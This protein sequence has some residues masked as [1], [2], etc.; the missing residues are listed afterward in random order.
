MTQQSER[1]ENVAFLPDES[2]LKSSLLLGTLVKI[3]ICECICGSNL[4]SLTMATTH[5]SRQNLSVLVTQRVH[6]TQLLQEFPLDP[7]GDQLRLLH[8]HAKSGAGGKFYSP[9]TNP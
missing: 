6:K 5:C 7:A 3:S 4:M 2:V 8:V 1:T 9:I